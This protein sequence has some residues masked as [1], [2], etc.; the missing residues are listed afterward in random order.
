MF[1]A[2]LEIT[3]EAIKTKRLLV[4]RDLNGIWNSIIHIKHINKSFTDY[5]PSIYRGLFN[6]LSI[7][8]IAPY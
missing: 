2:C 6:M 4:S 8:Y 3:A 1:Q 7:L 5:S